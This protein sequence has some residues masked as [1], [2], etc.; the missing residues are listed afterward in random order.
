MWELI[1]FRLLQGFGAAF[2]MANAFTTMGDYFAPAER[3][4]GPG[5]WRHVALAS[6]IGPLA[7]GV[8]TDELSWRW[9]FYINIPVGG[10]GLLAITMIMPRHKPQHP[11]RQPT[12]WL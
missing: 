8:L 2:I 11:N 12:D 5:Y 4:A 10:L 6:I 3:D 9:V 7:G 1:G